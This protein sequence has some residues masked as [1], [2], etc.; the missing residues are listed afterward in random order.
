MS[1]PAAQE[2]AASWAPAGG[3]DYDLPS[4]GGGCFARQTNSACASWCY[5][6]LWAGKVELNTISVACLCPTGLSPTWN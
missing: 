6:G 3:T 2:A 1:R 4:C 5:D